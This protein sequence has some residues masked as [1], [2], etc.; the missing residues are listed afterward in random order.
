M[1][2]LGLVRGSGTNWHVSNSQHLNLIK[3]ETNPPRRISQDATASQ[4]HRT[5]AEPPR[6]RTGIEASA[7][8]HDESRCGLHRLS[9]PT[10]PVLQRGGQTCAGRIGMPTRAPSARQELKKVETR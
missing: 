7:R 2:R 9:R 4:G 8:G 6:E 1:L 10:R 3:P 5:T